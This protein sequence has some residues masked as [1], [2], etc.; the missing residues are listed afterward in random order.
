MGDLLLTFRL[1]ATA[2]DK[3]PGPLFTATGLAY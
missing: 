3:S 2:E 1:K